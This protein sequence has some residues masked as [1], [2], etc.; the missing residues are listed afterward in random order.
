MVMYCSFDCDDD[1]DTCIN[2]NSPR[3]MRE[4][5]VVGKLFIWLVYTSTNDSHGEAVKIKGI[6]AVLPT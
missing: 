5:F 2:E 6:K 1:G 3:V 4:L